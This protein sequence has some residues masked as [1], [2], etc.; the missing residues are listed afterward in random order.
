MIV[1]L[2]SAVSESSW[3]LGVVPEEQRVKV[4]LIIEK[5][6]K[7]DLRNCR[8]CQPHISLWEGDVANKTVHLYML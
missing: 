7:E 5:G 6:K 1:R 4:P 2:V 8:S 3:R